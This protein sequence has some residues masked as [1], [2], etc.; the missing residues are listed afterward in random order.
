MS[1]RVAVVTGAGRGLGRKIA[2]RLARSGYHVVCT[3]IDEGAAHVTA[4]VVDGTGMKHDVRDADAHR[5]V[6]H[7]AAAI[8]AIE[9]WVNNAGVLDIG[10]TWTLDDASVR[11]MVEVNL[12]GVIWGSHAAVERMQ[13]GTILNVASMSAMTPTPGLA[14]YGATKHGVL[15]YSLSLASELRRAK[16]P[17]T[18]SALL[19]DAIAGEMTSAFAHDEHAGLLFSTEQLTLDEVADAAAKLIARPRLVKTMPRYRAALVHLLR[20]FPAI[21]LPLLDRFAAI[22]RRRQQRR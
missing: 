20:P 17:I 14:V 10:E 22:G 13:Q 18:V 3:D 9:V 8:G 15:G 11:R 12:L 19:P 6:A 4:A 2:E 16:R 5:A 1:V 21:G 7:A